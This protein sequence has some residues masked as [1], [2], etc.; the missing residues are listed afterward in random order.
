MDPDH[1]GK[2]SAIK[3]VR[4][5]DKTAM[6]YIRLW[7]LDV[8]F[9]EF[10]NCTEVMRNI[11]IVRKT[12]NCLGSK[13]WRYLKLTLK[14]FNNNMCISMQREANEMAKC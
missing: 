5:T 14:Q 8:K 13:E 1:E 3:D 4:S 7:F 2:T 11:S 9:L 12:L 6:H 10:H